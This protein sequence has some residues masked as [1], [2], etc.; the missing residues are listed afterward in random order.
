MAVTIPEMNPARWLRTQLEA[1]EAELKASAASDIELLE[2]SARHILDAGGKR[3]RPQLLLLAARSVGYE[4]ERAVTL[5]AAIEL[6]HTA[7]LVHDDIVDESDSRRGRA[8]LNHFWGNSASVIMGDYLVIRAF[9]LLARDGDARLFRLMCDTIAHMCEGEVLQICW[10]GDV[11]MTE[12]AYFTI[13]HQKTAVLMASCCRAGALVGDASADSVEALDAFGRHLGMAFQIQD[14]V[15]DLIGDEAALGKPVGADL[16]EGKVTLP[17]IY[18]LER[19]DKRDRSA[20]EEIL[21]RNTRV[22]SADVA[23]AA[24]I[25]ARY[26]GFERARRKARAFLH[27]AVKAIAVLPPSRAKDGLVYLADRIVDRTN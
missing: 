4:G 19:A 5:A 14:D 8:T 17:L 2:L 13:I 12:E 21:Q 22:S 15:L 26:D 18:A 20:L 9:S 10:R 23:A 7:T 1:V 27:D 3:L 11:G 24:R 6:I 16:R 25:I